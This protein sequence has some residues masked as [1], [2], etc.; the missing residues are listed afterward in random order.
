[1]GFE[2]VEDHDSIPVSEDVIAK[3]NKLYEV[4]RD[5]LG[6]SKHDVRIYIYVEALAK[7]DAIRI[8]EASLVIKAEGVDYNKYI[9][10]MDLLLPDNKWRLTVKRKDESHID[11][12]I[13]T[14]L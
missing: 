10:N 2:I 14:I 7:T 3:A 11:I 9:E 13:E 4:I 1:M 6:V 8:K 12:A 5:K